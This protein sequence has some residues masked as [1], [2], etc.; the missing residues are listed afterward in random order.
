MSLLDTIFEKIKKDYN[1]VDSSVKVL[2]RN[3][4]KL[5][6]NQEIKNF[7]FLRSKRIEELLSYY[8][9]NTQQ[10][11]IN[12]IVKVL[13]IDEGDDGKTYK[14]WTKRYNDL[15][16][17]LNENTDEMTETQKE[18]WMTW[19]DVKAKET[20]LITKAIQTEK[21]DDILNAFV[22]MLYTQFEP[23]RNQDYLDMVIIRRKVYPFNK[24]L[25]N[26]KNYLF[27]RPHLTTQET[28]NPKAPK[29]KE[30][31]RLETPDDF[32]FVFNK[33]KTS[34]SFGQQGYPLPHDLQTFFTKYYYRLY[35]AKKGKENALL[36]DSEGKPLTAV[37]SITRILN[38]IF[39]KNIGASMLRHIYLTHK[40]GDTYKEREIVSKKMGHSVST[41]NKYVKKDQ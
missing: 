24:E 2:K 1:L 4:E 13:K 18:N 35:P 22:L 17:K 8:K 7:D 11:I 41:Q 12:S 33:F 39:G 28:Y 15:V 23:R 29:N 37:N 34:K 19:D 27:L 9:P 16:K 10:S 5:A 20:E 3:I 36:V 32:Y 14:Y 25:S 21:W 31:E 30:Q 26:D 38:K 40:Y 6:E